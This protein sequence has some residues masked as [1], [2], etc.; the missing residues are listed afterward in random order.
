MSYI[1]HVARMVLQ[2]YVI[3]VGKPFEFEHLKER[4][5]DGEYY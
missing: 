5:E 4:D 2:V 3:L 1:W